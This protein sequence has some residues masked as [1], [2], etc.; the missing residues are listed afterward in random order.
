MIKFTKKITVLTFG[1]L[2]FVS[3]SKDDSYQEISP[4]VLDLTQVPYQTLSEYHFF[5]GDLK[6]QNPSY[7]VLPYKPASELFTDYAKKKRFVWMPSGTK[8]TYV[9]DYSVLDL[10]VGAALVKNFYYNNV[11]PNNSTRIIETRIMIRKATG[12]IYTNYIWNAEQTEAYLDLQG[13]TTEVTWIDD[14]SI[15]RTINYE[16]P[17]DDKCVTCHTIISE[18]KPIGIKPQSLNY[19]YTYSTGIKNQLTKW[20]EFGY[21][22]NNLPATINS[23]V[24]Y[25]D[26]TK[27]LQLRVRSYFDANC[28]HCHQDGGYANFFN[29][30]FAFN[31]TTDL[32]KMGVCVAP[33]HLIP[34]EEGRIIKPGNINQSLLYYRI[35]TNDNFYKMPFIGRTIVHEEAVQMVGDWINSMTDCP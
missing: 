5:D 13:S 21:L 18:K 7:G 33:N 11:Q 6:N 29:L 17:N 31:E 8:A 2:L 19:P 34:G 32:T 16:V 15:Q 1:I 3:C 10:P 26:V 35:N 9:N 28:A 27:P 25:N 22:E 30:K 23:V 14:N 4:V 12:W 20:K 24:D